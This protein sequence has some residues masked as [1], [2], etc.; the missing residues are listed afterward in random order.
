[1]LRSKLFFMNFKH[2]TY[3]TTL[4]GGAFFLVLLV[5]KYNFFSFGSGPGSGRVLLP[6]GRGRG[7]VHYCQGRG[8]DRIH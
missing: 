2:R 7:R 3:F 8:R 5:I 4:L 6:R 1:M